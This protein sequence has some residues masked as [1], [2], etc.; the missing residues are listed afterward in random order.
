MIWGDFCSWYLEI[1]KPPYGSP[2]DRTTYNQAIGYFEQLMI[3]LHPVMPFV[4][5]EIWHQLKERKEGEDC[6]NSQYP[7]ADRVN[8]QLIKDFEILKDVVSKIRDIRQKNNLKKSEPLQASIQQSESATAFYE[9]IGAKELVQKLALLESLEV[10]KEEPAN[11]VNFIAGTQKYYVVLNLEIDE[12][13]ERARLEKELAYNKGFLLSVDKKLGNE[14]FV[15]NAPA[16]VVE[17][18]RK[19]QAY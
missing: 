1:I 15:N 9:L 10:E 19:K 6:I 4:T 13:A 7:K 16:A 17:K 8:E 18:E 11:T 12:S 2:I 14:R 5:E 3:I